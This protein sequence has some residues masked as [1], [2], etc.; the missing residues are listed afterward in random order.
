MSVWFTS[1]LHLGHANII[2]YSHR[3]FPGV[4]AMN[5]ALIDGWNDTVGPDDD[6]WV[7]GDFALGRIDATLPRARELHGRKLL[8]CGNHDRCWAGHGDRSLAWKARYLQAGFAE[9]HQGQREL[10]V[11]G[12]LVLA[13]H[14]PYVGDSHDRDRYLDA[15]PADRGQWLLHGHVHEKWRQRGRM[16]NVGVD[17][18]GYRPVSESALGEMMAAGPAD[19]GSGEERPVQA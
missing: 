5:R 13:C 1:D 11:A 3:P 10:S 6:V 12:R 16:I 2:E 7:L 9:V 8:L 15:R 17:A 4:E 18:W 14:F 19:R